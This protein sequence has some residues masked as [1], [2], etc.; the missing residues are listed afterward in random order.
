MDKDLI[1]LY[2]WL[3]KYECIISSVCCYDGGLRIGTCSKWHAETWGSADMN[4]CYLRPAN[5]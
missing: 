2:I 1:Y 4:Y 3:L 5:E